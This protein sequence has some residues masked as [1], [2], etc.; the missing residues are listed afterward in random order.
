MDALSTL[1][2]E[3]REAVNELLDGV[4]KMVNRQYEQFRLNLLADKRLTPNDG[5][6]YWVLRESEREWQ[7]CKYC[8]SE[9]PTFLHFEGLVGSL[10]P[11]KVL[12]CCWECG[13]G[14]DIVEGVRPK[15]DTDD[16]EL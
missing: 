7:D 14:L 11:T 9:V 2:H 5:N 8:W 16:E 15:M 1:T 3:Q 6:P 13:A 4:I 12:R 10:E